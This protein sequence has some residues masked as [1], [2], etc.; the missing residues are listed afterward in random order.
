MCTLRNFSSF[1]IFQVWSFY[2]RNQRWD[3]T[4]SLRRWAWPYFLAHHPA[5]LFASRFQTFRTRRSLHMLWD[6]F[7]LAR[8]L[9]FHG[10][11]WIFIETVVF[12]SASSLVSRAM[13]RCRLRKQWLK[14]S[15]EAI[16][17]PLVDFTFSESS[18]AHLHLAV[19]SAF[20]DRSLGSAV[21]V[22]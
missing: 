11:F 14:A 21:G 13:T 12:L 6:P 2:H 20:E 5:G 4:G 16:S 8:R 10:V 3:R 18:H 17:D 15:R 9:N 22:S 7:N 1:R 19:K